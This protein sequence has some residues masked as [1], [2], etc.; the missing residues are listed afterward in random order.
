M[1]KL[2]RAT[3]SAVATVDALQQ[4]ASGEG[5]REA[6]SDRNMKVSGSSGSSCSEVATCGCERRV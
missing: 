1:G 3:E 2:G 4:G 6:L 5:D